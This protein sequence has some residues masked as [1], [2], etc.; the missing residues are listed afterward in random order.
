MEK[1]I[2]VSLN[3]CKTRPADSEKNVNFDSCKSSEYAATDRP[4]NNLYLSGFENENILLQ[5]N[6]EIRTARTF[7]TFFSYRP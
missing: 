6:D 5:C 4:Y 7:A 3:H 1:F 2:S